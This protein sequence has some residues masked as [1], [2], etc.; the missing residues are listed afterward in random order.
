MDR[1]TYT[2]LL[3]AAVAGI[4][5]AIAVVGTTIYQEDT[6]AQRSAIAR[7]GRTML[8]N[9]IDANH[10]E[11]LKEIGNLKAAIAARGK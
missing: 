3:E 2:R 7:D 5:V 8:L 6:Q 11:T 4:I 1:E 10:A 9:H